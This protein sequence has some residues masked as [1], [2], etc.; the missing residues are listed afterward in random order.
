MKALAILI[1]TAHLSAASPTDVIHSLDRFPGLSNI[2]QTLHVECREEHLSKP[3]EP[4]RITRQDLKLRVE[5]GELWTQLTSNL[6]ELNGLDLNQIIEPRPLI[7]KWMNSKIAT[8]V[9]PQDAACLV[10]QTPPQVPTRL[11]RLWESEGHL[12]VWLA[13]D[14]SISRA[15]LWQRYKGRTQR[16]A[17]T[18]EVKLQID[19]TFKVEGDHLLLNRMEEVQEESEGYDLH[20][21]Y[22]LVELGKWK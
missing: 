3:E 12:E 6:E 19:Y 2:K 5:N 15:R 18:E 10:F 22:R 20:K 4:P 8:S 21:R 14:C 9:T 7:H 1:L 17:P 16:I 11:K 13:P